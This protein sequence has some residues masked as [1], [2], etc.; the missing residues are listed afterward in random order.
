MSRTTVLIPTLLGLLL[1]AGLTAAIA[2]DQDSAGQLRF[3]RILAPEDRIKDWPLGDGRYLPMDTAEFERLTTPVSGNAAESLT[4]PAVAITQTRYEAK[5][6]GDHLTGQATA[7]VFLNGQ[8]PK[9]LPFEPC[10]L[11]VGKIVWINLPSP[12]SE[13]AAGGKGGSVAPTEEKNSSSPPVLTPALS[14]TERGSESRALLGL[15]GNGKLE[16][17]VERNGL[18]R[19]DWSLAGRRDSADILVFTFELPQAAANEFSVE[20]PKEYTPALDRGIVVNSEPAGGD[21]VRW[22]IALGGRHRFHMRLLPAGTA[23]RRPQLALLRELRTYDLS[24]RGVEVSAQWRLQVHNEPLQQIAVLLDPGLELVSARY[25]DELLSWTLSPATDGQGTRAVLM[26]SE[27]IRDTERV[28]RLSALGRTVLDKPWRLPRIRAEGLFWQEGSI[29]VQ[30]SEPLLADRI[31]PLGCAQTGTGPLSAPRAGESVQF[32]TFQSDATVELMVARRPATLQVTSATSIEMGDEELSARMAADLHVTEEARFALEVDIAKPWIVDTVES[33]PPAAVSDWTLEPQAGGSGRLLIRLDG[34][35]SSSKPPRL[36]ISARRPFAAAQQTL[37]IHDLTPLTFRKATD[38]RQ[39]L[40]VRAVGPYVLKLTGDEKIKQLRA[41]NLSSSELEL[42][43]SPPQDL[44]LECNAR[45]DLLQIALVGQKAK[46]SGSIQIDAAVGNGVIREHCTMRCIPES[47]RVDR[48]LVQFYPRSETAPVWAVGDN[49]PQ[50]SA[51]KLS[52]RQQASAGWDTSVETWE[53]TLRRPRSV[54][55]EIT[56]VRERPMAAGS[57]DREW[58]Q[59]TLTLASMPE[60]VVQQGILTV[61]GLGSRTLRID[62][63]RLKPVPP[64]P[65]PPD[66]AQ[67][68]QGVFRYDPAR[69]VVEGTA[70]AVRVAGNNDPGVVNTWVWIC[71]LESWYQTDGAARHQATYDLQSTGRGHLQLVMPLGIMRHEIRGV[72]I[73]GDTVAWQWTAADSDNRITIELPARRKFPRVAIQW[74]SQSDRLGIFGALAPSMPEPDLPVLSRR[75]TACLPPGYTCLGSNAQQTS[76]RGGAATWSRRLFGPFGRAAAVERF[77]P[78]AIDDWMSLLS[79]G[80]VVQ[81]TPI[82]GRQE[83]SASTDKEQKSAS[84]SSG[85]LLPWANGRDKSDASVEDT[86]GWSRWDIELVEGGSHELQFVHDVSIQLLGVVAFLLTAAL[87]CWTSAVRP[88]MLVLSLGVIGLL[89]M[90]LP[91]AYAPLASGGVLGIIFG[92]AWR[93]MY[94]RD[95]QPAVENRPTGN[96]RSRVNPGSTVSMA[97]DIGLIVLG[98]LLTLLVGGVVRGETPQDMEKTSPGIS[99]L[100]HD[101]SNNGAKA[102]QAGNGIRSQENQPSAMYR[103]LVPIDAQK[104][105]VGDKLYLPEPFYQ[106]LYRRSAAEAEKPR[107]WLLRRAVYRGVLA[108]EPVSGRLAI[109]TLRAEFGLHVL[110]AATRV[111]IPLRAEGANLLPNGVLLDGRVIEPEWE[112]DAAALAFVVAEP[113]EYRLE[114]ALRPTMRNTGGPAGLDIVIPRVARSRLELTLPIDVS[115]VEV[116]SALGAVAVERD[117]P[118]LSAE[119]G[120]ADRL[121]IRWR[122]GEGVGKAAPAVDLDQFVWL[123]VQPGSVVVSAKFKLRVVE[124]QLQQVQMAVDPRLRL[125]PLPGDDPPTVQTGPESGQSRLLAFRWSKPVSDQTTLETTFLLSG[126]TG[127]GNFRLPQI[128]LLDAQPTRRWM[129][130]SVD[131]SLD[132]LEQKKQPLEAVAVASFLNAWNGEGR[133][134]EG[135]AG[136]TPPMPENPLSS[137]LIPQAAYQLPPGEIDWTVSTRPHEPQSDADQT[138]SLC[139]EEDH[140]DLVFEAY[141]STASGYLFQHRLTAPHGLKIEDVSLLEGDVER[142]SRWSQDADGAITVFLNS[143]ASGKQKLTIRGSLP[144]RLEQN[145]PLPQIQLDRCRLRSETIRLFRRPSVLLTVHGDHKLVPPTGG[146]E[147]FDGGRLVE[148]FARNPEKPVTVSLESNRPKVRVQQVVWPEPRG[149]GWVVKMDCRLFV[150]DGVVDQVEMRAPTPWNGPYQVN[151]PGRLQVR[152]A[153][154]GERRLVYRPATAIADEFRFTIE[155]PLELRRDDRPSVPNIAVLPVDDLQRWILLPS[156]AQG[157]AIHWRTRGLRPTATPKRLAASADSKMSAYEVAGE[158]V[159]AVL[160]PVASPPSAS[161]VRLADITEA[162]S[163][164]G[165]CCGAAAFDIEAGGAGDCPLSLPDGYELIQVSVEGMSVAPQA[166]GVRTWRFPLAA[167]R[168]PQRVEVL[169][170]GEVYNIDHVRRYFEAPKLGDLPVRETLWTVI[171]PDSWTIDAPD[172]RTI[173]Q[174]WRQEWRRMK[175]AVAAL[176]SI[177][178]ATT[179]DAE[180]ISRCRRSWIRRGNAARAALERTVAADGLGKEAD[181]VRRETAALKRRISESVGRQGA[182]QSN[183]QTSADGQTVEGA[184]EILRRSRSAAQPT[185]HCVDQGQADSLVL[186]CQRIVQA[187]PSDRTPTAMAIVVSAFLTVVGLVGLFKNLVRRRATLSA[188]GETEVPAAASPAI[189]AIRILTAKVPWRWPHVVGTLLG[190]AWWLWLSPSILGLGIALVCVIAAG[191]DRMKA[192]KITISV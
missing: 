76:A 116:P 144:C 152:E 97:A 44:L 114:V 2:A 87:G 1:A 171:G 138:L 86:R 187:E 153:L 55:F 174:P 42:F 156:R 67:A 47:G 72:W 143:A 113:G 164:D 131:P 100:P 98:V 140:A 136:V 61:R 120:P 154:G 41:D 91:E 58:I 161:F 146:D 103:V 167:Q 122:E 106:E 39:L 170:R 141:V 149:N 63:R 159:Q 78:L 182:L 29:T 148:Q 92:L 24:M 81:A 137:T 158:A 135:I 3:R 10:N 163:A 69:G 83:P 155:G 21:S 25:G 34:G 40:A 75:W 192:K 128:E 101:A 109:D 30:T 62:N 133:K 4:A 70:A 112:A 6:D 123:K 26:L 65:L 108:Q 51:R 121:T 60:A 27:P 130:L 125:L 20:L 165:S 89:A 49:D 118:R 77:D 166:T 80:D 35:Q 13:K 36:V 16:T 110:S 73:D 173:A 191:L 48:L 168:L 17:L 84:A 22:R 95:P 50:V 117:P 32:Q 104:Q 124:G 172:G 115:A 66:R 52:N 31:T 162:W 169:F 183:S 53:L 132:R 33:T 157:Q 190:L 74:T 59:E 57:L 96:Q 37:T 107:G 56:A 185:V 126:A 181:N 79:W 160:E 184:G 14:Q 134:G 150:Q 7:D 151:P 180:E 176:D 102:G 5:L 45:A 111:R 175:S 46:Y 19:F 11:A 9:M 18:L 93:W 139:F 43:A 85:A 82:D 15:G 54:P 147:L 189:P 142:A 177:A 99:A 127:V 145:Q 28:I 94:A 38:G 186:D 68:V 12:A 71:H 64:E 179:D 129:A 8:T 88:F 105:P 90:T 23:N 119:L 188:N 178:T